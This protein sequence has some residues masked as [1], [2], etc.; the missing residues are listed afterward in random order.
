MS[1]A[2]EAAIRAWVNA[3]SDLKG[4]GN[5]LSAGAYLLD[6]RSPADG[7]Y[8]VL[9]RAAGGASLVAEAGEV[10]TATIAAACYAGTQESAEIAAAALRTAFESLQGRPEACGDTGVRVLVASNHQGPVYV[11]Q[12]PDSG[13]LYCFQVNADFV[14]TG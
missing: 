3:R 12:G 4:E 1:I 10:T 5:P 6:Q 7:A 8:A 9:A 2:A 14:L 11:D 13:E